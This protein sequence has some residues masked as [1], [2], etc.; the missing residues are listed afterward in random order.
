[1]VVNMELLWKKAG[2]PKKAQL[3]PNCADL[4]AIKSLLA[5][6]QRKIRKKSPVSFLLGM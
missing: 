1:M 2:N 6:L 3:W 5:Q 4:A